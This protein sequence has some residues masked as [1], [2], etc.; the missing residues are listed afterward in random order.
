MTNANDLNPLNW[1][2]PSAL[3]LIIA[4]MVPLLG[5]VFFHWQVFPIMFLFWMENV[6]IG[7]LNAFKMAIAKKDSPTSAKL[8]MIPFFLIHYGIFTLVHGVF[9]FVI[10]GGMLTENGAGFDFNSF[11]G[12]HLEWG[13]LALA[14]SHGFSFVS[15]YIQRGEYRQVSVSELMAQPYARIVILHVTIIFGGFLVMAFN[16]ATMGL[17]F[18]VVVKI[19][20]DLFSHLKAHKSASTGFP[21]RNSG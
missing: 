9:I 6:V 14:L 18:L 20:V 7:I 3:V 21:R 2:S 11:K 17:V 1:K 19:V 5:V 13:V 4:N 8:F 15:N 12:L 16:T 10:F